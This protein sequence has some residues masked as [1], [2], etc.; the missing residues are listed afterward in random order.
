MLA[1]VREGGGGACCDL[2]RQQ[3]PCITQWVRVLQTKGVGTCFAWFVDGRFTAHNLL[4]RDVENLWA[5]AGDSVVELHRAA[6]IAF[7]LSLL[8]QVRAVGGN[9]RCHVSPLP[10]CAPAQFAVPLSSDAQIK[11]FLKEQ[12]KLSDKKCMAF[13]PSVTG[14]AKASEQASSQRDITAFPSLL[15]VPDCLLT[16]SGKLAHILSSCRTCGVC[17]S[18][19]VRVLL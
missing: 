15:D 10:D 4:L 9:A 3:S 14:G 2:L 13:V 7:S 19:L 1:A 11:A 17:L 6:R 5:S 12:F 16:T 8:M 18:S